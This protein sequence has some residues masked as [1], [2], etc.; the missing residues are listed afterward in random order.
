MFSLWPLQWRG[1]QMLKT[2]PN[3]NPSTSQGLIPYAISP[4]H[5]VETQ[6]ILLEAI[7]E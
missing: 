7:N 4:S 6:K 1:T 5:R 3:F 2:G